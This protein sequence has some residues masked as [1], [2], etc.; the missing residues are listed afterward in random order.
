M[1]RRPVSRRGRAPRRR[2]VWV[3]FLGQISSLAVGTFSNFDVLSAYAALPGS[4][5]TGG[6]TVVRVHARTFVTSAVAAGD[7]LRTGWIVEN[8]SEHTT[9]G[10]AVGT[11][12]GLNPLDEP[13]VNWMQNRTWVGTPGY[14]L[15]S[16]NNVWEDDIRSKRKI[17]NMGDTL[18]YSVVHEVGATAL[19]ASVHA[20][21]LLALP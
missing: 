11:A 4:A 7:R 1:R 18:L 17:P 14:S 21:V 10:T 6:S 15:T 12:F 19:T 13:Y 2:L 5:P 9:T 16:S 3:D 8:S 20:R